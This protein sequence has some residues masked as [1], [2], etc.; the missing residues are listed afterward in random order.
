M[1]NGIA[2][3][4]QWNVVQEE[5][6][7]IVGQAVER[8]ARLGAEPACTLH[9]D[10]LCARQ[11]LAEIGCA[12]LGF[13]DV[14]DVHRF[15]GAAQAF[16]SSVTAYRDVDAGRGRHHCGRKLGVRCR[17]WNW[18]WDLRGRKLGLRWRICR[19]ERH[20]KLH[21]QEHARGDRLT[22]ATRRLEAMRERGLAS[23][24]VEAVACSR[25]DLGFR[26][27]ALAVYQ[28]TQRDRAFAQACGARFLRKGR[29]RS[30]NQ[31]W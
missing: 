16:G 26:D 20:A 27:L 4:L 9:A 13:H 5:A 10:A 2:G 18:G 8:E 17:L 1:P 24:L 30:V 15:R 21:A 3:D 23:E 14:Y 28:Y 7:L 22:F 6:D 19:W 31:L 29:V 11:N 25:D 12:P